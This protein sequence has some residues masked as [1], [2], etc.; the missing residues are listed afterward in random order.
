MTLLSTRS[1]YKYNMDLSKAFS[2][3]DPRWA[4]P[5]PN[6]N[7]N[8]P[9][10]QRFLMFLLFAEG[11]QRPPTPMGNLGSATGFVIKF[12]LVAF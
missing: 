9:P 5:N 4:N 12:K 3:A 2:L 11:G 8:L 6:P 1:I 7:P 10:P